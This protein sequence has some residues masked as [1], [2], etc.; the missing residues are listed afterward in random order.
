MPYRMSMPK[1][2]QK[3]DIKFFIPQ[4][5]NLSLEGKEVV[6]EKMRGMIFRN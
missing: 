2:W 1:F 5:D 3:Q 6:I 4:R